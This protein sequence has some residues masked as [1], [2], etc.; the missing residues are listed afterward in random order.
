MTIKE[1]ATAIENKIVLIT[2]GLA[3]QYISFENPDTDEIWTIRVSNHKCNPQRV[4][5]NTIS[6]VV[7]VPDNDMSEDDNYSSFGI[8]KKKFNSIP[9]QFYLNEYGEFE[10]NFLSIEECLEYLL[11]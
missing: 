8:A 3:S 9:N 2:N 1:L 6:F 7:F 5:N 10:E 4:D 11:S